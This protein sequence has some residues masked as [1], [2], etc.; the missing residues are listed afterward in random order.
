MSEAKEQRNFSFNN[1]LL[2]ASVFLDI[3]KAFDIV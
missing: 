3:E 2:M 1:N